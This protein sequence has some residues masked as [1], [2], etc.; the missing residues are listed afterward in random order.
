[1]IVD[2]LGRLAVHLV[3]TPHSTLSAKGRWD[4]ALGEHAVILSAIRD[5]DP[6]KARAEASAHMTKAR[7]IRLA[8]LR[9]Q[10]ASTLHR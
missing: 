10:A 3:R 1:M 2:L 7:E 6:E 5:R 4:E 9:E 8:L